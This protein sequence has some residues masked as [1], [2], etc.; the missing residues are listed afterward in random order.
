[1]YIFTW[2]YFNLQSKHISLVCNLTDLKYYNINSLHIQYTL[3]LPSCRY[4]AEYV[5]QFKISS[6]EC[7]GPVFNFQDALNLDLRRCLIRTIELIGKA[8]D[9]RI[10]KKSHSFIPKQKFLSAL[11]VIDCNHGFVIGLA[12]DSG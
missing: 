9:P 6:S 2:Q 1:M 11:K 8:F 7:K 10:M 5:K 4:Y 3:V 12:S